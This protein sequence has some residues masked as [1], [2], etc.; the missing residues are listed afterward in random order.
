MAG[1]L[2]GINVLEFSQVIAA[3]FA[4]QLMAELGADVIKVEPPAGD[5]WR[6]QLQF[7]PNESRSF[8]T[9]NRG[10]RSI[11]LSLDTPEAQAIARRL[12]AD[13]D[14]VIINYRP[15]VPKKFNIDY[16][17]LREINHKLVYVDL[18]AFGR[19]GPWAMR[20]GYDGVVQAT[21][22]LMAGE[23]KLREDGSPGTI[24][25]TA[26]ADFGSGM[27]LADAIIAALYQRERTGEGQLVEGSLFAT[28][29]NLQG[30]LIMEHASADALRNRARTARRNAVRAGGRFETAAN[31]R[32]PSIRTEADIYYR[33]WL[34]ADG[35]VAI[36]AQTPSEIASARVI[37]DTDLPARREPGHD[38]EDPA[39]IERARRE[40]GRIATALAG[41]SSQ[42][43]I[44][45]CVEAGVPVAPVHF[46][47]ELM[48]HPQIVANE[49]MMDLVHETTGPQ[50]MVTTPIRFSATPLGEFRAS[51]PLGRD[52]D[53]ILAELGYTN[54]EVASLRERGG[55]VSS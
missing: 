21:A 44:D 8:Q 40:A 39:F 23:A 3:P 26:I 18:T 1:P 36:G 17:S 11:T 48:E 35:A 31:V 5:S 50:R 32:A 7:A 51:P 15:D 54:E 22:G 33:C 9:L 2:S 53:S 16:A 55:V 43:V 41:R 25:S 6:L 12:T 14:V 37:F 49:F 13:A 30:V 38:I 34:C 10:K 47:I 52:T 20:P 19:R 24:S 4:G 27:I 45:E 46:P 28:A 42:A 29:L